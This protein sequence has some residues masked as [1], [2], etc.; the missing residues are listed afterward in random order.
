[1]TLNVT[2]SSFRV[3]W[4]LHSPWPRTFHVQVYKGE[5]LLR[6]ARTAGRSLEVAGLEAG[7]LYVV[8]T[9]YQGCGANVTATLAVRTGK[10]TRARSACYLWSPLAPLHHI[11]SGGLA[12]PPAVRRVHGEPRVQVGRTEKAESGAESVTQQ[13]G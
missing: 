13:K 3:S 4:R 7:E 6:S 10:G 1:M 8:R 12:L 2:S 5:E 9:G 11:L